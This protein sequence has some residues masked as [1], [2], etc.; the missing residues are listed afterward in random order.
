M[1]SR[2][3]LDLFFTVG[4]STSSPLPRSSDR[5]FVHRNDDGNNGVCR[6]D[7][8]FCLEKKFPTYESDDLM[9]DTR[10]RNIF[11]TS[12]NLVKGSPI[13]SLFFELIKCCHNPGIDWL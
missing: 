5:T 2:A 8:L 1:S 11:F 4:T 10:S 7:S 9:N 6:Y 13:T 3:T 12:F